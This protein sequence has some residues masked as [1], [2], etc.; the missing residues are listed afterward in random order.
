M[1]C[2]QQNGRPLDMIWRTW[3][4]TGQVKEGKADIT[5]GSCPG[6][7]CSAPLGLKDIGAFLVSE[8]TCPGSVHIP[9]A[10]PQTRTGPKGRDIPAQAKGL[11]S[12][13]QPRPNLPRTSPF[14]PTMHPQATSQRHGTAA[15]HHRASQAPTVRDI[16]AQAKGLGQAP[17]PRPDLLRTSPFSPTMH[18]Q[19]TRLRLT[20][21]PHSQ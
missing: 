16:P 10:T 1:M 19:A 7:V 15:P 20:N 17:Q 14:S 6:L 8:S 12:A 21:T 11:G 5:Q 4:R 13:P 18:P 3:Q 2:S 9:Y